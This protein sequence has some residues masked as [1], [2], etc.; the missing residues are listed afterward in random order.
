MRPKILVPGIIIALIGALFVIMPAVYGQVETGMGI[1]PGPTQTLHLVKVAPGNYSYLTYSLAP[2]DQL[3][4]TL[5]AGPQSVDFFLMN[6][7]NFS[8]W[9]KSQTAPS[10]VYPQSVFNVKNY[11]FDFVGSGRNQT[12]FLVFDSTS[13]TS[14]TDVLVRSSLQ[15]APD[16][17]VATVPAALVGIGVVL[18]L[19][20]AKFGGRKGGE[21]P[22]IEENPKRAES[23]LVSAA[24]TPTCR[25]CGARLDEG[26]K[27][28][29]SCGRSLG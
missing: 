21:P 9:S 26:S 2:N 12:Y 16:S 20:G 19:V 3:G 27:F 5:A 8:I 17:N 15:G 14:S 18:A 6:A 22:R 11:T 28:C 25:F 7:G 23:A 29:D 13:T 1:T 24:N 10:Q 4:V